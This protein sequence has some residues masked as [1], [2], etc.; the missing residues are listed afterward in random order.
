MI[1]VYLILMLLSVFVAYAAIQVFYDIRR[2]GD[3]SSIE[4]AGLVLA[5][6]IGC[7]V[8]DGYKLV[9]NLFMG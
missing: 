1:F 8:W 9:A 6:L 3:F 7:A 4:F 2:D 5:C